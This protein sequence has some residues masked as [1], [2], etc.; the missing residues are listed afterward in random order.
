[1]PLC[2]PCIQFLFFY[3][4]FLLGLN[5]CFSNFQRIYNKKK[6]LKKNK[7]NRKKKM[8]VSFEIMPPHPP[9]PTKKNQAPIYFQ[10]QPV[11][12]DP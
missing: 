4:S 6:N 9:T 3:T 7:V 8:C 2:Q 10:M 5:E 1:M 12:P 11:D